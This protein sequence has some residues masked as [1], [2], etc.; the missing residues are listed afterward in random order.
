MEA[1]YKPDIEHLYLQLY[2]LMMQ[3]ARS[4]L[5][6]EALAE[7][8]VQDAFQIACQKPDEL[9]GSQNPEG[10]LFNTL[11]NVVRNTIRRRARDRELL[12]EYLNSGKSVDRIDEIRLEL[13]YADVVHLE[14]FQLVKEMVLEGKSYLE[15]A[16]EHRISVAACRKRMQRAREF[17][18]KKILL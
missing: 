9:M 17:L 14:E 11:K 13:I 16:A 3:Y 8:A 2:P 12:F 7:E 10:W 1:H 18:K 4:F 15:I 6:S 5:F